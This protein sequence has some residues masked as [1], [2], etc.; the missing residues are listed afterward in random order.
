MIYIMATV[1]IIVCV[2]SLSYDKGARTQ[3]HDSR[4]SSHYQISQRKEQL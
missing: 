1:F 2:A 3:H 4:P